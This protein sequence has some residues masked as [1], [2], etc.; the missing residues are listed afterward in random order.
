MTPETLAKLEALRR[1]EW[2]RSIGRAADGQVVVVSD[3]WEAE[4]WFDG[5]TW[6]DVQLEAANRLRDAIA[7]ASRDRWSCWSE[8][9]A[10]IRPSVETLV[11]EKVRFQVEG[12]PLDEGV[13]GSI[14]WDILHMAMETEYSDLVPPGFFTGIGEW[15][16]RGHLPC[17]WDGPMDGGRLVIF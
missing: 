15:Y 13:V 17:G 10:S 16:L 12:Q 8:L 3:G 5:G 9:V 7:S 14:A 11:A 1:V 4:D 6:E 2:F